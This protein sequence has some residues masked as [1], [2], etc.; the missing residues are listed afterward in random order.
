[1]HKNLAAGP[2]HDPYNLLITSNIFL[3]I[4]V[5]VAIVSQS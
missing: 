4:V 5:S 2:V 3:G 1:M